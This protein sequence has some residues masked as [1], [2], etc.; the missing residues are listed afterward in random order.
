[1]TYVRE[2][3]PTHV[4]DVPALPSRASAALEDVFRD[5]GLD[6]SDP[7]REAI[8]GHL[9]LLLAWTTAINLTAVRDPET[10]VERHVRDSLSAIP[11]LRSLAPRRLLDLGSGGG[12]PGLPLAAVLPVEALL[13][14][15]VAKKVRFLETAVAA[16]S[17]DDRVGTRA[18]RAEALAADPTHRGRWD[19]VT[20]R[21]VAA[22]PELIELALPLLS[23]GG[24]LVA[25]KRGG[26]PDEIVAGGRAAAALGGGRP[27]SVPAPLPGLEGHVL[28]TVTKR[29]PTPSAIPRDPAVRTRRPW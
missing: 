3:L 6:P 25:W 2:P 28:V 17:L 18:V 1:M 19:V 23:P 11:V 9:R 15:P 13:V 14:D 22:L 20:A 27:R 24:T 12:Y 26:R 8:E 4:R 7:A 5:V 29:G 10:A 16:I 21:A